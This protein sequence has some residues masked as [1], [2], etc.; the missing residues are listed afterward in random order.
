VQRFDGWFGSLMKWR[1]DWSSHN[2]RVAEEARANPHRG[3]PSEFARWVAPQLAGVAHVVEVGCGAGFDLPAY[4]A[5]GDD[6]RVRRVLGLDYALPRGSGRAGG[7]RVSTRE[8][9]LDDL[10]DVLTLGARLSRRTEEQAVVARRLLETLTP[11]ATEAFFV[12][13]SMV[14]RRGGRAY[15]EGVTRSPRQAQAWQQRH[16]AGRVRSLDPARVAEQAEAAGGRIVSRAGFDEAARAAHSGPAV[17]WRLTVAWGP[18]A[19][20]RPMTEPT[21]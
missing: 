15:L 10:R 14:L 2:N 8:L 19:W 4:A 18:P 20:T 1:R 9:C 17:T 21:R 5:R 3:R 6:G 12:L 11:E 7:R 13:C 16:E